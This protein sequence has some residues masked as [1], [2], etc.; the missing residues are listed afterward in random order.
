MITRDD[1]WRAGILVVSSFSC[2]IVTNIARAWWPTSTQV[3][4]VVSARQE[5]LINQQVFA[6]LFGF[7]LEMKE[8][9]RDLAG[10]AGWSR[11]PSCRLQDY[12][13]FSSSRLKVP[14]TTTRP[15]LLLCKA[16]WKKLPKVSL[17]L[18]LAFISCSFIV[19]FL[20]P[21]I[22]VANNA[23]KILKFASASILPSMCLLSSQ[24]RSIG[25]Q[26]L[27]DAECWA[28]YGLQK[29]GSTARI[30]IWLVL[31]INQYPGD[32]NI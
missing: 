18:L 9:R 13:H 27:V 8:S 16:N 24:L 32:I 1:K 5:Y 21:V 29:I 4:V 20:F 23:I 7:L 25:G 11:W 2:V 14:T 26:I 15:I 31:T 28:R 19:S 30:H 22:V 6:N 3:C 12:Y 17:C 10:W